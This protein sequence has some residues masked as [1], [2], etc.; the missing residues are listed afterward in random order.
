MSSEPRFA[1]SNDNSLA[2]A[3]GNIITGKHLY[4]LLGMLCSKTYYFALRK[5]Y[6]GGGIEGELK[7]NRLKI[8][9]IPLYH[10]FKDANIF[11][12]LVSE[13]IND[14]NNTENI[15]NM[16]YDFLDLSKEEIAFIENED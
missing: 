14:N 15:E 6:M 16:I 4:Y 13:N 5:Y 8:L 1:F 3:P 11:E 12:Q 7:T 9:P 2:I 10:I